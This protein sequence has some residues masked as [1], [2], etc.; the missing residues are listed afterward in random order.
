MI[1]KLREIYNRE[2]SNEIATEAKRKER[3]RGRETQMYA[4]GKKKQTEIKGKSLP[5]FVL[6]VVVFVVATKFPKGLKLI[7]KQKRIVR[8]FAMLS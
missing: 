3:Q 6:F 1:E 2:H 4:K 7:G 5:W 8:S